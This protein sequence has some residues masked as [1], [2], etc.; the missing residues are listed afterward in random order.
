MSDLSISLHCNHEI[1]NSVIKLTIIKLAATSSSVTS[2]EWS[3]DG[4]VLQNNCSIRKRNI[5]V[6][7]EGGKIPNCENVCDNSHVTWFIISASSCLFGD[8]IIL[9]KLQV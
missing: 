3:A 9:T 7:V 2:L 5:D 1:V 6:D 8:D 4:R